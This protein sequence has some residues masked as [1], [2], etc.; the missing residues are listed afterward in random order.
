M[1][2]TLVVLAAGLGSRFG[3]VKQLAAVD[4]AGRTLIEYSLSDAIGAGFER[5]V[6]VVTRQLQPEFDE[7]IGRRFADAA[8]IVYAYQEIDALPPGYRVPPGRVKPWGTAQAVLSALPQVP[9][10]FATINA[11]DYYGA[12]AYS[13]AT[14]FLGTEST[15]HGL[16]AYRLDNT[17]SPNGTVSRGVCEVQHGRLAG[18]TERTALRRVEGGALDET[19]RIF[20]GDTPVSMNF[21]VFRQ[22]AGAAF[23]EQFPRFLDG[24]TP[25]T[26]AKA[27]FFLPDVG[28]A[29]IPHV[30][31]L[32]TAAVW[33]GVTYAD[34]LPALRAYLAG[35]RASPA[36]DRA[37]PAGLRASPT[38][39]RA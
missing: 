26:A 35:L 12:D 10:A 33:Q 5:I 1:S 17:L 38:G 39:D 30:R 18:I 32:P 20:P 14:A 28:R 31:V 34:D 36:G 15:D 22:D 37:S 25:E 19:G 24:L 11:D 4:D 13:Q 8:E 16:V 9:G 23:T 27:E 21:W 2:L 7:R 3:G 6:F 29:L